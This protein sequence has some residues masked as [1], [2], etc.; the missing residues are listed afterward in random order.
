MSD[1]PQHAEPPHKAVQARRR[2]ERAAR[3]RAELMANM[4]RRKAQMRGRALPRGHEA[5]ADQ[6]GQTPQGD[7]QE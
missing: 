1:E 3:R 2:A 7:G 5:G 6:Q 4:A